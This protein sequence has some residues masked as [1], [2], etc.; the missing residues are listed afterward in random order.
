MANSNVKPVI[1]QV[2]YHPHL[3][4][5]E[6]KAFCEKENIQLEAWSPMKRGDLLKEPVIHKIA[7]KYEKSTAQVMLRWDVQ[8]NV[9]T[10]PKSIHEARIK[11][12][13]DIFDF[14]LS[15]EEIKQINGLNKNDRSGSNPD[16][17]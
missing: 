7:A 6:L 14:A 9:V 16:D 11:A 10:I 4:Q 1:D 15:D 12:N 2:E 5:V 13:A 3:T 8:N 17:F